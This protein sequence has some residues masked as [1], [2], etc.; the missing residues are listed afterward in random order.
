M[1]SG[2]RSHPV[3]DLSGRYPGLQHLPK[4]VKSRIGQHLSGLTSLELT[5]LEWSLFPSQQAPSSTLIHD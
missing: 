2:S 5:S 3:L 4:L 1:G